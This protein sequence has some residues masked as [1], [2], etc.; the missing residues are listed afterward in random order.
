MRKRSN[1]RAVLY[2]LWGYQFNFVNIYMVGMKPKVH[3][4]P[5][6]LN[7]K[8]L[9]YTIPKAPSCSV[10]YI[11]LRNN[12]TAMNYDV[13]LPHLLLVL[14]SEQAGPLVC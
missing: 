4:F 9:P 10:D 5:L 7:Y 13:K 2:Q 3:L 8:K 14:V 12:R 1:S 11:Y 6:S